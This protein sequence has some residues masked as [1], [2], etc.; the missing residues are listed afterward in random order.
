MV[1]NWRHNIWGV[2]FLLLGT[3]V[4]FDLGHGENTTA[5][6]GGCS[7]HP[8]HDCTKTH[9]LVSEADV[10]DVQASDQSIVSFINNT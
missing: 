7:G 8:R 9:V 4:A 1:V 6:P 2:S 10:P 3:D 5:H